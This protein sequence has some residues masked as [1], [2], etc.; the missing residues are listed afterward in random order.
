MEVKE[1]TI[2]R[3]S[4]YLHRIVPIADKSGEIISY[5][6]KPLMLEF[7][8]WDIM[9]V[10]IG[11]ALLAIPVSLT[12]EVWNLGKSLPMTNILI[13]TFLSLIMISVF[14]YFNFYKVT[15]KG[16]VTEFIKRVI[17]TYLIS[18]IVVAVILTIIEKC[19]WGI[20]NALAIKR[21]IIV[22]F[23]AAMSGT[24]SDTIK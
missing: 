23:P 12:E 6:L 13:I 4:G 10:V 8:P 1:T 2:K 17:G 11:S 18:L 15:L 21:I 22:A 5:A 9:Q 20:D 3:I 24:L 7:K 14:V 19:P 16:Y